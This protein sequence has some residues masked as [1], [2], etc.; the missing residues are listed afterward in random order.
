VTGGTLNL[1]ANN[2]YAGPTLVSNG[3]LSVQG[4]LQGSGVVTVNSGARL[5][6][7]GTIAGSVT[8][9]GTLAPGTDVIGTLTVNGNLVFGA[10][11][12]HLARL[13]KSANTNDLVRGLTQVQYAG[14]LV[15]TN[16]A[17]SLAANDSFK[18]F[19]AAGAA[20]SG[21]FAS[22]VP[23]TPGAG[24]TWDLTHLTTDGTVRVAS[25]GVDLTPI[26]VTAVFTNSS[27]S[28]SWPANHIGWRLQTQTN[29]LNV[30]LSTNW[31]LW[32]ASDVTTTNAIVIPINT[33]NKSVFY[34]LVSP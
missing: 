23:A 1:T 11:A 28:L 14:T 13:N 3:T 5:A 21:S 19:D 18:L 30:G 16:L 12:T 15:L 31:F 29:A 9:N 32:T 4:T 8:N 27:V 24:L 22:V 33:S 17:G 7:N 34:R 10:G 20:Y 26:N 2:N 25:G 6:G